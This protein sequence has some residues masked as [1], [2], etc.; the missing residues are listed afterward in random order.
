MPSPKAPAAPNVLPLAD[1][2][3]R[4][5]DIPERGLE[6]ARAATPAEREE[7]RAALDVLACDRFE[8]AYRVRPMAGGRYE[9]KGSFLAEVTQACIVT[10][11]PVAATT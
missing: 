1:W 6:M 8:A 11:E 5:A 3:H 10:L 4:T 2:T 9:A 7:L